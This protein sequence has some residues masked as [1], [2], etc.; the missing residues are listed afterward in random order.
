MATIYSYMDAFGNLMEVEEVLI[1]GVGLGVAFH[2]TH[3]GPCIP[4]E[5]LPR[6]AAALT[7]GLHMFPTQE[8][9][10]GADDGAAGA[11]QRAT[12]SG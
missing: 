2:T 11:A 12:S 10:N 7:R 9:R 6:F 3:R 4:L 8:R 5:E 1:P